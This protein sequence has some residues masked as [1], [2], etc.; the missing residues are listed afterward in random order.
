MTLT[1]SVPTIRLLGRAH[2]R[3][4]IS[5]TVNS[6]SMNEMAKAFGHAKA[7]SYLCKRQVPFALAYAALFNR[8]PTL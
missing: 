7:A 4:A 2:Q 5:F 8:Q 6:S 1:A 3:E